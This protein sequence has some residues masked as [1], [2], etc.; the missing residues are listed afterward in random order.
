MHAEGLTSDE[1]W[2][3]MHADQRV[4]M[5]VSKGA[6]VYTAQPL[7]VGFSG[8][9]YSVAC[10]HAQVVYV[11]IGVGLYLVFQDGTSTDVLL[12]FSG[13]SLGPLIGERV[14][15]VMTYVVWLGYAFNLIVRSPP[16][17]SL[18]CTASKWRSLLPL[19]HAL[20]HWMGWLA[21]PCCM[22]SLLCLLLLCDHYRRLNKAGELRRS[23]VPAGDVPHDQL[24]LQGGAPEYPCDLPESCL[25]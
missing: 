6:Q 7:R 23:C 15:E 17:C 22:R 2:K 8:S 20:C 25:T 9:K 14:A 19:R 16:P 10:A 18:P 13:K 5:L 1:T 24:G 11:V 4:D 12:N 3:G 21:Y